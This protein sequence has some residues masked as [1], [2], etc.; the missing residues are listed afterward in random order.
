MITFYKYIS[1]CKM[2]SY[3][4]TVYGINISWGLCLN[5]FTLQ[6]KQLTKSEAKSDSFLFDDGFSKVS[7]T[8]MLRVCLCQHLRDTHTMVH[9]CLETVV[10]QMPAIHTHIT[11]ISTLVHFVFITNPLSSGTAQELIIYCS[12][13]KCLFF[14]L[15]GLW[16]VKIIQKSMT[17]IYQILLLSVAL[18]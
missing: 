13:A 2:G 4:W 10:Q 1:D 18:N 9:Q 5:N 3:P 14:N 7:Y 15:Y 17:K 12:T 16:G 8:A 6:S 11:I